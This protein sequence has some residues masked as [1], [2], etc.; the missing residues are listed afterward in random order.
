LQWLT[1][2][3]MSLTTQLSGRGHN[4][5]LKRL[6]GAFALLMGIGCL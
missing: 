5:K 4:M 6:I 1:V 2:K 3:M